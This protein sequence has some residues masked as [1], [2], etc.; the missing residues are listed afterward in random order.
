MNDAKRN[1]QN[2]HDQE[3]KQL[4]EEMYSEQ[5]KAADILKRTQDDHADEMRRFRQDQQNKDADHRNEV[6]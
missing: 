2:R 1:T 6:D 4:R 5:A 3:M